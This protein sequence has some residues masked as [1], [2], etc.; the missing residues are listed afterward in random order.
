MADP[1]YRFYPGDY[2]RDTSGL[3]LMEHGAYNLLLHHYYSVEGCVKDEK[4]RLFRLC[5]AVLPEEQAAVIHVVETYFPI[6]EGK[7]TNKR[8]DEEISGRHAFLEEQARKGRLGGRPKNNPDESPGLLKTKPGESRGLAGE[9]PKPK[10]EESLPSPSPSL[11]L[12]PDLSPKDQ[13]QHRVPRP[14]NGRFTVPTID[15]VAE[16]CRARNNQVDA[17]KFHAYYTSNGWKV[18]KNPMKNWKAAVVSTW[19]RT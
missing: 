8:A 4:P 18:G 17:V 9:K 3:S 12:D 14:A 10:P 11:S 5:G 6:I 19:E 13:K 1:Y 7:L 16:Y 2:L 15:Q